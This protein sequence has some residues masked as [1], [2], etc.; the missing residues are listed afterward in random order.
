MISVGLFDD[1][2]KGHPGK[3]AWADGGWWETSAE[4]CF[5][6]DERFCC[7][8][9]GGLDGRHCGTSGNSLVARTLG[10]HLTVLSTCDGP[11]QALSSTGLNPAINDTGFDSLSS[12]VPR[13]SLNLDTDFV[14]ESETVVAAFDGSG[15]LGSGFS[16]SGSVCL[17][18]VFTDVG[19]VS[20]L[21]RREMAKQK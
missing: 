8:S 7:G 10:V 20:G 19:I 1:G 15:R 3:T 16:V 21:T 9:E 2:S 5:C 17:L 13:S 11:S 14:L 12:S 4:T 6:S 18:P